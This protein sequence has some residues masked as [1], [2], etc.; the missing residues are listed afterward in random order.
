MYIKIQYQQVFIQ[1]LRP[2]PYMYFDH[3]CT[4]VLAQYYEDFVYLCTRDILKTNYYLVKNPIL[5][6]VSI[7]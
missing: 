6:Q 4:K 2:N 1:P 7:N 5:N 3:I